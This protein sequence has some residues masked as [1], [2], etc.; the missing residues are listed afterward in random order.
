MSY[1]PPPPPDP[2]AYGVPQ[3]GARPAELL[4]RFVAR[5]IDGLLLAVVYVVIGIVLVS[6]VLLS[7]V[8]SNVAVGFV[9]TIILVALQLGY[10]VFLETS[11]GQT[12]GKMVMKLRVLGASGGNPTTEE[13]L[14]RNIWI[15]IGLAGFIPVIGLLTGLAQLAAV[16]AIAVTIS[17][18]TVLR[19]GWHDKFAGT[20]VIKQ[21]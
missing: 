19:Q 5:L 11:R 1:T 3:T 14:K 4:D 9:T 17:S 8:D 7:G 18:D 20:R 2:S 10:F 16:I 12:V 21:G 13:S 15:A 6:G